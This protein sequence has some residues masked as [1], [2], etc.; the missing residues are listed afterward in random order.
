M[1]APRVTRQVWEKMRVAYQERPT[2]RHVQIT[3]GVG[4]KMAKRAVEEG[5]QEL[6]L[7]PFAK[8]ELG[9]RGNQSI[10]REMEV[11]RGNWEDEGSGEKEAARQAAEEAMAARLSME[12]AMTTMKANLAMATELLAKLERN[13]IGLKGDITPRIL[14]QLTKSM[15]AATQIVHRAMDIERKRLGEPE[16]VLGIQIGM[17][18][19][20]LTEVEL[21]QIY[22]T[23]EI[24]FRILSQHPARVLEASV[25]DA[26]VEDPAAVFAPDDDDETYELPDP[27][28]AEG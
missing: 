25:E 3:A 17:M 12:S 8:L 18:L 21:R 9:K 20:T 10:A 7:A 13:E 15:D 23:G 14:L 16:Q 11:L 19:E 4:R 28:A 1:G 2:I 22:E 6:G 5:W 27:Q 24:P 26:P